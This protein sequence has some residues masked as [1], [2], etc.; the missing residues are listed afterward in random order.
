MRV[1]GIDPGVSGAVVLLENNVPI[2]WMVMPTVKQGSTTRVNASALAEFLIENPCEH[3][4]VEMVGA[5]PK[6]GV[7]SMFNFGHSCGVLNGVLSALLIPHTM[8]TPQTWKKRAGLIGTD[9]DAARSRGLQL[10]PMWLDLNQTGKGQALADAAL[11]ARY[12]K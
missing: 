3:A 6:Q 1:I 11:I 7:T 8:V 5:M 10:W 2:E 12:G 4:L 9:K